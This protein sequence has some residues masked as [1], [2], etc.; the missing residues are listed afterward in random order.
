MVLVRVV[1]WNLYHGRDFPPANTLFRWRSRL[2]RADERAG[3]YLQVN[4]SLREEFAWLLAARDWDV[5]L[6]QE[7]PPRWLAPL[8]RTARASG[9]L[10]L[11]SRN[12]LPAL[13]GRLAE[14]NPDLL[15]SW[16]GG[17]N[18]LLVRGRVLETRRL[19]LTRRPERRR[20]LWAQV[21]VGGRQ[22]CVGCLH[23][24]A[25]RPGV[26]A[27]ELLRAA[28][29]AV[30]WAE[31]APLVLGGDFNL[32]PAG[33]PEPFALL[34]SRY[35]LRQPTAPPAIDHLL[36][37]GLTIAAPPRSLAPSERELSDASGLRI[38]LSDH[39]IV[40]ATFGVP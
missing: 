11:T 28:A 30:S 6:L 29:H 40:T 18:Q 12:L 13:Q 20:L 17:S 14:C 26:A 3:S 25:G 1:S 22:L 24:S 5:A 21:D 39:D 37:R 33:A 27:H 35:G 9:V 16:E 34:R 10:A 2:R 19:T 36:A 4:R 8:A 7:A 32:C 15:A 23:A 38:R 31:G